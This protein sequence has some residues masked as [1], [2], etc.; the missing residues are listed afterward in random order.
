VDV[1]VS[2]ALALVRSGDRWLVSRRSEGRVFAGLWEFPGGKVQP[3]EEPSATAVRETREETGL[4][5]EAV[6]ELGAVDTAHDGKKFDLYLVECRP[7]AGEAVPASPAVTEVRWVTLEELQALPMPPANA[8]IIE[9][10]L[11]G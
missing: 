5:V 10:L 7:L 4:Q 2:V 8:R 6:R 11:A 9:R 1:R 3:G